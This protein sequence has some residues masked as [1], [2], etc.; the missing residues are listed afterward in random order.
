MILISIV[1]GERKRR[2]EKRRAQKA[3]VLRMAQRN[4]INLIDDEE[5]QNE[6]D[7]DDEELRECLRLSLQEYQQQK[8]SSSNSIDNSNNGSSGNLNI[9]NNGGSN[10][11][12]RSDSDNNSRSGIDV[13]LDDYLLQ[14]GSVALLGVIEGE[15]ARTRELISLSSGITSP[16]FTTEEDSLFDKR[17]V[18]YVDDNDSGEFEI[19]QM[20]K[21]RKLNNHT[22]ADDEALKKALQLSLAEAS[23]PGNIER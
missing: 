7:E 9:S 1:E 18:R 16:T 15:K 14:E 13:L 22:F 19:K 4:V 2:E 5:Q 23:A 6:D 8:E 11:D 12:L 21:E 20:N 10:I 17:C 3:E